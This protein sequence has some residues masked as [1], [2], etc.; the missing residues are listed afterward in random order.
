MG[1]AF[2]S[3]NATE[4]PRVTAMTTVSSDLKMLLCGSE[5]VHLAL[6]R[7]VV[8]MYQLPIFNTTGTLLSLGFPDPLGGCPIV[9]NSL[10]LDRLLK[11]KCQARF[12]R[13]LHLLTLSRELNPATH[14]R[15]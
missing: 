8:S 11:S 1:G 13:D 14:C 7:L 6:V 5:I 15:S 12:G 4:D 10:E 3:E 2:G 9:R